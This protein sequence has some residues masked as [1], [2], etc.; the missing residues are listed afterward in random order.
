MLTPIRIIPCR[1]ACT[2]SPS[3]PHE[4]FR[5]CQAFGSWAPSFL[6]P[7]PE[8]GFFA[9]PLAHPAV[10]PYPPCVPETTA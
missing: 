5:A 2:G 4:W 6:Y 7:S 9:P 8:S 3:G 1:G 10:L